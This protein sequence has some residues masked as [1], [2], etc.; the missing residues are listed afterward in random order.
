MVHTLN[1]GAA[2]HNL[3]FTLSANPNNCWSNF[4]WSS[5]LF[6]KIQLMFM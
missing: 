2:F 1:T 4:K 6:L 3:G 5:V